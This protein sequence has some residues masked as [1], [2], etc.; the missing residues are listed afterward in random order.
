MNGNI[1]TEITVNKKRN[2]LLAVWNDGHTS[3]YP[4]SLVRHACPCAECRSED[5]PTGK[6]PPQEVFYMPMENT[7]ETRLVKIEKVGTYGITIEW[8]DG[9]HFG[10]YDWHYLRALCPCPICREMLIYGQ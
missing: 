3:I 4:F 1:P 8:E 7:S 9:H 2:E 6:V 10:I 5:N